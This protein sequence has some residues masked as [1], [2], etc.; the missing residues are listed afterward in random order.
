MTGRYDGYY[1]V[2]AQFTMEP[3]VEPL[4]TAFNWVLG[5]DNRML[6]SEPAGPG[7]RRATELLG[8][9]AVPSSQRKGQGDGS[10]GKGRGGKRE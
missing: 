9:Y 3:G 6:G 5:E 1:Q 7:E 10:K 4:K 8:Q 2:A